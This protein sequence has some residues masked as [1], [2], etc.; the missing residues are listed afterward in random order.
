MKGVTPILSA[1]PPS[2]TLKRGEDLTATTRMSESQSWR[3]KKTTCRL[4][5]KER[6]DSAVLE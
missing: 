2:E 3:E 4:A 5:S 6:T 1:L